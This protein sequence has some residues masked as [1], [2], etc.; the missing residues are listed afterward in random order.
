[1]FFKNNHTTQRFDSITEYNQLPIQDIYI[2]GNGPSLNNIHKSDLREKFTIGTNRSWLW[3]KTNILLW[4]DARIA[5][6][7][8]FFKVAKNNS[9]W[10]TSEGKGLE[11][12]LDLKYVK[13]NID[14]VFEDSWKTKILQTNIK[15][16]GIIFHAI[17]IAKF[18]APQATIHLIGVDLESKP[19]SHHF[20]AD[21]PGFN[22]G[23]YKTSW[24]E[25]NFHFQKRLDMMLSNFERLQNTGITFI[26][27]SLK[28]RLTELF[29]YSETIK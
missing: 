15:W 28:S 25:D 20:F 14:Y 21:Y 19:N 29:G 16:N 13:S 17:A 22:Q 3:D 11:S 2:L 8:D 10:I 12:K 23:F 24:D 18:I 4:R 6:E 27:H 7:L 26:N 1:M 9:Q 5:E